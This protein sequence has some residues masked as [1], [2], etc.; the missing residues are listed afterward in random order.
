MSLFRG[1]SRAARDITMKTRSQRPAVPTVACRAR[2]HF[3]GSRVCVESTGMLYRGA[4]MRPCL[5]PGSQIPP[6][7]DRPIPNAAYSVRG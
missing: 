2:Q 1:T 5:L 4:T 7:A 6:P 3:S